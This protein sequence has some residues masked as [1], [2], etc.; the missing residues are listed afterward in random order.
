MKRVSPSML[1]LMLEIT[2]PLFWKYYQ[3]LNPF[4]VCAF[5]VAWTGESV[6]KNWKHIAREYT[7]KFLHQ[8]QIWVAIGN[9]D[10]MTKELFYPIIDTGH[11]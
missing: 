6:S 11:F 3:S 10:L 4:D 8:K 9:D 2:G 1:I 7:E 5:S